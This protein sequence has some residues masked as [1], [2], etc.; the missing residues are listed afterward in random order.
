MASSS[1]S[2]ANVALGARVRVAAGEG[3]VRFVGQTAFAAGKWVGIE[4]D[5]PGSGKNDGSV[6][7]GPAAAANERGRQSTY[8]LRPEYLPAVTTGQALL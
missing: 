5:Q 4:L 3:T 8:L 2:T 1:S 7:V 6:Q